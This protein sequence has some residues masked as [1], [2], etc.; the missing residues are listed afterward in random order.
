MTMSEQSV[1]NNSSNIKYKL[2]RVDDVARIL[3]ISRTK[4]Y[5]L[6]QSGDLISVRF[7]SSVRVRPCDLKAFIA[8]KISKKIN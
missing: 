5:R 1:T 3:N 4:A 7:G 2:L 6:T 8:G